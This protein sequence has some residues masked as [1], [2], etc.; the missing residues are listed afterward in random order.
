MP[1]FSLSVPL[2]NPLNARSTMKAL[3]PEVSREDQEVVGDV[4]E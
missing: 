4:G 3:M 1:H 2:E